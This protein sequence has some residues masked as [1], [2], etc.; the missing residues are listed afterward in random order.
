MRA[1][2]RSAL[3]PDHSSPD[4]TYRSVTGWDGGRIG[5]VTG[6]H[7]TGR[8]DQ[9]VARAE[10]NTRVAD[11]TLRFRK[12]AGI[13]LVQAA[14]A[15]AGGLVV[16]YRAG[17]RSD[18]EV[19]DHPGVLP[20]GVDGR[21]VHGLAMVF[22]TE[23][24]RQ[25]AGDHRLPPGEFRIEELSR[26]WARRWRCP[27]DFAWI[28]PST[29]AHGIYHAQARHQTA[30]D[31]VLGRSVLSWTAGLLDAATTTLRLHGGQLVPDGLAA[32][33]ERLRAG[34]AAGLLPGGTSPTLLDLRAALRLDDLVPG[35]VHVL[36]AAWYPMVTDA[37][38]I[39]PALRGTA[40]A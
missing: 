19:R 18:L 39:G 24:L 22:L 33:R 40:S 12:A 21:Q 15:W 14:E 1:Y 35:P 17:P 6:C 38:E 8:V 25:L 23:L 26:S 5:M 28:E 20:R 2:H 32:H 3:R 10:C 9:D 29:G 36:T 13:S 31:P 30:A 27:E 7:E 16:W 37:V 11:T 34:C 4:T